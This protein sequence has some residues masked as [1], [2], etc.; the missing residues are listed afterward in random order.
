[1]MR[2]RKRRW[3]TTNCAGNPGT[4][5]NEVDAITIAKHEP[6]DAREFLTGF[7]LTLPGATVA[8]KV[9]VIL[10]TGNETGDAIGVRWR[11]RAALPAALAHGARVPC[12]QGYEMCPEPSPNP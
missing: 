1:M 8:L 9:Y 4:A 12:V 11:A 2:A 5:Y 6:E 7:G 10:T 3:I